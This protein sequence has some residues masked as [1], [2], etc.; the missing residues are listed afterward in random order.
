MSF[1]KPNPIKPIVFKSECE[2]LVWNQNTE[3]I[4]K[5]VRDFQ[6]EIDQYKGQDLKSFLKRNI[7]P[8]LDKQPFYVN[9]KDFSNIDL[10][11]IYNGLNTEISLENDKELQSTINNNLE[12][13]NIENTQTQQPTQPEEKKL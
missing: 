11:N 6:E 8:Q 7:L 10:A 13:V 3:K 5:V 2:Y 4:E 12:K 9:E 1:K